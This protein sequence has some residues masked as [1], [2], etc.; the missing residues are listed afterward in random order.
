MKSLD[1]QL[2]RLLDML[3]SFHFVFSSDII[4]LGFRQNLEYHRSLIKDILIESRK[5]GF[6]WLFTE[7]DIYTDDYEGIEDKD[8][9]YFKLPSVDL[10]TYF[11]LKSNNDV[12]KFLKDNGF[13]K[14]LNDTEAGAWYPRFNTKKDAIKCIKVINKLFDKE[15]LK[16]K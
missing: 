12:P 4:D 8:E 14:D 11:N 10:T 16:K 6:N 15:Y 13:D 1:G 5:K 7:D 3:G 2:H 9:H